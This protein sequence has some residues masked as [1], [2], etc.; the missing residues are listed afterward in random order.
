KFFGRDL[1]DAHRTRSTP[2]GNE[3][4][5][6]GKEEAALG[7]GGGG[8][9]TLTTT[10]TTTT[11]TG[12]TSSTIFDLSP[13][14]LTHQYLA[15][16]GHVAQCGSVLDGRTRIL[17]PSVRVLNDDDLT[18]RHTHSHAQPTKHSRFLPC[19]LGLQ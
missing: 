10:T 5:F 1:H 4:K 9:V 17:S 13:H 14:P 6:F 18:T 12:S 8:G 16:A 3:S 7:G 2:N 19:M 11:T 15:P